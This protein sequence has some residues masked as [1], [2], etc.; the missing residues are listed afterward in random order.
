MNPESDA[1]YQALEQF[2]DYLRLIA[3]MECDP[4]F[5]GK[6]D[7]S[8]VVQQTLLEAYQ[9]RTSFSG[10]TESERAAW[11]RRILANNLTDAVRKA[12]AGVRD[13]N[14]ERSLEAG[15]EESSSRLE[16]WLTAQ[17]SS[18]SQK[19]VREEQLR[20]LATALA[21]LPDDQRIVVQLHHLQ[22][23]SLRDVA[24]HLGR[25]RGAIASLI[26]RGM[27]ALRRELGEQTSRDQHGV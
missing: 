8:G 25:T 7:L 18:P 4:R 2:R 9:A 6:L 5:E 11:L 10:S 14:R 20:H 13:V 12:S 26:F 19:V 17:Q 22:G 3:R 24:E 23:W 1:Q 15:I 27:S 16:A 21:R